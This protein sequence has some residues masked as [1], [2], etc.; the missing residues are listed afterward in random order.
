VKHLVVVIGKEMR[1]VLVLARLRVCCHMLSGVLISLIILSQLD[2]RQE[3]L[4]KLDKA[5]QCEAFCDIE[6]PSFGMINC[7]LKPDTDRFDIVIRLAES[8]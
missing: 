7:L 5:G 3:H 6:F 2:K 1:H 8:N 4:V